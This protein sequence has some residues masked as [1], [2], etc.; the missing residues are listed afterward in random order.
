VLPAVRRAAR[1][2]Y[3]KKGILPEM[4]DGLQAADEVGE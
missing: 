3:I 1:P 2:I 4:A